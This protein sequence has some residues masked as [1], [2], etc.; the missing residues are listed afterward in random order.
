[1]KKLI[2]ISICLMILIL[3]MHTV[4]AMNY[5]AQIQDHYYESFQE[6]IK[7]ILDEKQ[8]GPIYL[9]DDVILD[10]GTIN[11][12]IEIIEVQKGDPLIEE[13]IIRYEDMYGRA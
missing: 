3:N 11:K 9:L 1:M 8:K 12:D 5:Q 10:I 7:D 4:K 2:Q 13:D 6:A